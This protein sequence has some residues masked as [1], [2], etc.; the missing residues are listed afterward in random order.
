MFILKVLS[1]RVKLG[2]CEIRMLEASPDFAVAGVLMLNPVLAI[3]IK[4][5]CVFAILI[6]ADIGS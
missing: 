1:I 4:L 6:R 3:V 2:E 5:V